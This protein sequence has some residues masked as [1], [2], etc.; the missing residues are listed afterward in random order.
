MRVRLRNS[1]HSSLKKRKETSH[2]P[3]TSLSLLAGPSVEAGAI[4][5]WFS[6][7]QTLGLHEPLWTVSRIFHAPKTEIKTS[8][9]F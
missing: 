3:P 2:P 7:S 8:V 1:L 4:G 6:R 5:L 9:E